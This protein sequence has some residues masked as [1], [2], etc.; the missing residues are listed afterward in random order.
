M[1]IRPGMKVFGEG[2]EPLEVVRPLGSGA[3]GLVFEVRN[4]S[5][6]LY[7]LKTLQTGLLDEEHLR[8]LLNEG[9][10]AM[11]VSHPNVVRVHYFHDGREHPQL[12]PYT[13]M[14]FVGGGTL[15]DVLDRQRELGVP[16]DVE[17]VRAMFRQLAEGMRAVHERLV[18]R[19]VKP[20]NVLVTEDG[21]LKV[22]DFGLSKVVGAA[23]RTQSFKGLNH[24]RYCAPEAWRLETNAPTMDVYSMG[25]VFFEIATLRYP[26]AVELA[27]DPFDAFRQAHL[28]QAPEDPRRHNPALNL[29][30]AQVI[31]K[32]MDKRPEGRFGDWEEVLVRLDGEGDAPGRPN[33]SGLVERAVS[34]HREAEQQRLR[35]E[36]ARREREEY[37]GMVRYA[38]GEVAEAVRSIV[39]SFNVQSEF[40]KLRLAPAPSGFAFDIDR[41]FGGRAVSVRVVPVHEEHRLYGGYVRAWGHT[42]APSGRGFNLVLW[43]KGPEDL[44]GQ[45]RTLHVRNSPMVRHPDSRSEPFPFEIGELPKELRFIDARAIHVYRAEDRPFDAEMFIPLI[46]EL[47]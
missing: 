28:L 11:Q 7:A 34:K 47:V 10:A 31:M 27:G 36:A 4:A 17:T 44:Y 41:G 9:R 18:H 40:A 26:Y 8:A 6:E 3:F 37:E 20:D 14:E 35:E 15:K 21:A 23:T 16:F 19:D 32:M 13:V 5:G 25:I 12:P 29:D 24:I 2:G 22:A 33:V 43:S 1:D 45:W 42:K 39:D 46:E 30:L 38:F